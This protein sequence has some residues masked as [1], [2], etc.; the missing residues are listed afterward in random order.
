LVVEVVEEEVVDASVRLL[1]LLLLPMVGLVDGIIEAAN[2][3]ISTTGALIRFVR[4]R[5]W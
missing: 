1:L 2:S 3:T 4:G 5:P